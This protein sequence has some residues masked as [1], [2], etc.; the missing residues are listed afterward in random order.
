MSGI[1]FLAHFLFFARFGLYEDDLI[2]VLPSLQWTWHDYCFST[3]NLISH[4]VQGRPLYYLFQYAFAYGGWRTGGLE[5]I[6]GISYALVCL[7]ALLSF[8][9]L[10]R[11]FRPAPAFVGALALVLFPVDTSRQFAMHQA[12]LLLPMCILLAALRLFVAGRLTIAHLAAASL[13]FF[14]E[15]YYLLF[16][17]APLLA[18]VVRPVSRRT[19]LAH[20]GV[21]ALV[22]LAVFGGRSVF[23]DPRAEETIGNFGMVLHRALTAPFIGFWNGFSHFFARPI[24]AWL[25][26]SFFEYSVMAVVAGAVLWGLRTCRSGVPAT[27][28]GQREWLAFLAGII[29]WMVPYL[30]AFRPDYYPPTTDIGRLTG[31]H[32]P[33]AFGAA[34]LVAA[35]WHR[36]GRS[37]RPAF[38]GAPGFVAALFVAGAAGFGVQVQ[39]S[40]YV[41]QWAKQRIF[42]TEVLNQIR[43]IQNGDAIFLELNTL[44]ESAMPITKGFRGGALINEIYL[45]PYLIKWPTDLWHRPRLTAYWATSRF[46][47]TAAG[48]VV[49][50][51]EWQPD[52]WTEVRDEHLIYFRARHGR[53]E[54]V[55]GPVAICGKTFIARAGPSADLNPLP[56][57]GLFRHLFE[58][59]PD[60]RWFSLRNAENYP[61]QP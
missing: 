31:V 39:L 33:A 3:Q 27:D 44:D 30:L 2:Y 54:R 32:A 40:E 15:S 5:A 49:H 43:D 22:L 35:G 18:A 58:P 41:E 57:T 52:L 37:T 17:V 20:A 10:K 55:A 36:L 53:L 7:E 11:L 45:L 38:F 29:A 25:H 16:L 26:A 23:H 28:E 50:T 9:L 6:H 47:D 56:R 60:Q 24:D 1:V 19:F 51:P 48:R 34:L 8:L 46:H 12:A 4:F 14:Y 59:A 61:L 42:W 21:W 13:L